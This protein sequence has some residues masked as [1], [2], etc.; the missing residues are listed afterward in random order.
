MLSLRTKLP[1]LRRTMASAATNAV[2]FDVYGTA[3]TITLNRPQKLNALNTQMCKDIIPR[4]GEYSKSQA[5][6]LI[7]IKSSSEKAFCA[8]GDVVQVA[9]DNLSGDYK[10]SLEFFEAEYSLNYLLAIY[11]KPIVSLNNGITMGGGVGLSCHNPFRVVCETTRFAMPESAIGFIND[12]GTSFWLPKLDSNLGY[13][14]GVTGE[15]LSGVD[16]FLAGFGTHYVPSARYPALLDRL[17]KLELAPL[18][19]SSNK[20]DLVF[21]SKTADELYAL[22][23]ST[24]EEFTEEIPTHH[25]FKYSADELNTI[26]KCFNPETH[27]TID[28]VIEDLK[29]DGSK[30]ALKTIDQ[31][32]SKS[33]L[34]V[35]L[36]WALLNKSKDSTIHEALTRE[37]KVAGKLMTKYR[38]N[39]FNEFIQH[40]LIEKSKSLPVSSQYD[41]LEKVPSELVDQL[42]L[43]DTFSPDQSSQVSEDIVQ[44]LN[45][46]KIPK[47]NNLNV[48]NN[49]DQ[50]PTHMGLP[51]EV[52][53][54]SF[55]NESPVSYA[56]VV[57]YFQVKYNDKSG[58][59]YKVKMVLDRKTQKEGETLK[60][61]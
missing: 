16:T 61:A 19:N 49:F 28:E 10:K 14:L 44:D 31:L 41:T 38:A 34:S 32:Q 55:V 39:D 22:V 54:Q 30:F 52:E 6:N 17:S 40:K 56:D 5:A 3:R 27:T 37:L 59:I 23:N 1:S 4:L 25:Q 60:W 36:N 26:E 13:Y 15:E 11:S 58:S 18:A 2:E 42:V 43:L 24:I 35:K 20:N 50:Y 29:S 46:L 9:K 21:T 53:I 47:Y 8:G 12:V 7:V 33:P 48:K 57:K 45:D 51:T